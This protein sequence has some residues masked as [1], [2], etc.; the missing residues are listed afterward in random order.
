[1]RRGR[2]C[3]RR[4]TPSCAKR[5][6]GNTQG[7]GDRRPGLRSCRPS[8]ARSRPRHLARAQT[9]RRQRSRGWCAHL[10][11]PRSRCA[12]W[13]TTTPPRRCRRPVCRVAT[14][15]FH[16]RDRYVTSGFHG[17]D[18]HVPQRVWA[19]WQIGGVH[20]TEDQGPPLAEPSRRGRVRPELGIDQASRRRPG[21][22]AAARLRQRRLS[23]TEALWMRGL[24]PGC[25]AGGRSPSARRCCCR[26]CPRASPQWL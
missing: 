17:R 16:R 22:G 25:S 1:M 19:A 15:A 6:A 3:A 21:G 18:G 9:L 13:P 4:M 7:R 23:R 14:S 26:W 24:S 12:A 11:G 5:V 8:G 10:P 20:G 2:S